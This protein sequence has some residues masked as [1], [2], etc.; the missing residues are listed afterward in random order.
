MLPVFF[1][2]LISMYWVKLTA[3][4]AIVS[5][6]HI[7]VILHATLESQSSDSSLLFR[8]SITVLQAASSIKL[9][10]HIT[11]L[12]LDPSHTTEL[13]CVKNALLWPAALPS[14]LPR[15]PQRLLHNKWSI[16]LAGDAEIKELS[17]KGV[18][19]SSSFHVCFSVQPQQDHCLIRV[20]LTA[21]TD[22]ISALFC[23][24]W[25]QMKVN[26]SGQNMTL[27]HC[28]DNGC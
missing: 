6:F 2:A 1:I 5:L 26:I 25:R 4:L 8:G 14:V 20:L 15:C 17:F 9:Q 21:Q 19:L 7:I 11:T 28:P 27:L 12:T 24:S 22:W 3:V 10:H 13:Q 23:S 18:S 16:S